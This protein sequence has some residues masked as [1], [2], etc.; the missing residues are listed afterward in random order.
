MNDYKEDNLL[1]E[2]VVGVKNQSEIDNP[3]KFDDDVKMTKSRIGNE[4]TVEFSK[5]GKVVSKTECKLKIRREMLM[6]AKFIREN[7]LKSIT[8]RDYINLDYDDSEFDELY[9]LVLLFKQVQS[10]P[11]DDYLRAKLFNVADLFIK[12][13]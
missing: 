5:S 1:L 7:K 6:I 4:I 10:N 13:N 12:L 2:D 9:D 11:C 8:R 3:L